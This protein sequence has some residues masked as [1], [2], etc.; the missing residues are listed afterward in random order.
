MDL[1]VRERN[2]LVIGE[3]SAIVLTLSTLYSSRNL[4]N[5]VCGSL[6]GAGHVA[7]ARSTTFTLNGTLNS[8]GCGLQRMLQGVVLVGVGAGA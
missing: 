8:H 1:R 2:A 4:S 5:D 3:V 6:I 7:H